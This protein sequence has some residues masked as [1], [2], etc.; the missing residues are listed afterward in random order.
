M[1][2]IRYNREAFCAKPLGP[3]NFTNLLRYSSEFV[4]TVIVITEF[5]CITIFLQNQSEKEIIRFSFFFNQD[6]Y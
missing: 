2:M 3:K 5:D 1:A 4:I 6:A